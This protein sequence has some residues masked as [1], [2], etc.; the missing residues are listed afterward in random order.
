MGFGNS[1]N[2]AI[3]GTG[4]KISKVPIHEKDQMAV[5]QELLQQGRKET[6]SSAIE[7]R[8]MKQY[9]QDIVP[10]LAQSFT[11]LGGGAQSSGGFKQALG[12]SG[13]DLISQLASM[14][15]QR[16]MQKTQLGLQPQYDRYRE[17]PQEGFLQKMGPDIIKALVAA[18]V[19]GATGGP[20]GALAAGGGSLLSRLL[21]RGGKQADQGGAKPFSTPGYYPGQP[22]GYSEDESYAGFTKLMNDLQAGQLGQRLGFGG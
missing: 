11:S 12:Q 17:P 2:S 1:L 18:A 9:Y 4:E 13:A 6:D 20:G 15:Q 8:A 21:S 10:R 19:G 14:R 16:G 22:E 7:D 5:F 3:F